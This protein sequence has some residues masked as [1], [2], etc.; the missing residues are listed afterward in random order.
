MPVVPSSPEPASVLAGRASTSA[1]SGA[2]AMERSSSVGMTGSRS[3][4]DQRVSRA[5]SPSSRPMRSHRA[6]ASRM[7]LG[8]RCI[9]SSWAKVRSAGP[10]VARSL[11]DISRSCSICGIWAMPAFHVTQSTHPSTRASRFSRLASASCCSGV[12]GMPTLVRFTAPDR[13][14]GSIEAASRSCSS[15]ASRSMVMPRAYLPI[16]A[17]NRGISHGTA[18]KSRA[19]ASSCNA[20]NAMTS[21]TGISR[22]SA[23]AMMFCTMSA[24]AGFFSRAS[25]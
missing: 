9:P 17:S 24:P 7:R 10:P 8:R 20:M 21:A 19:W 16:R 12:S 3:G 23:Y 2:E 11:R 1:S 15:M 18:A 13:E 5:S 6:A 25:P 14:S 22:D 4:C